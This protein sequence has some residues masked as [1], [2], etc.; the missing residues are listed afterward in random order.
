[1]YIINKSSPLHCRK[2]FSNSLLRRKPKSTEYGGERR[3]QTVCGL[4]EPSLTKLS[5]VTGP[6]LQIRSWHNRVEHCDHCPAQLTHCDDN[7]GEGQ[8][9]HSIVARDLLQHSNHC[10]KR[11]F[12]TSLR[13]PSLEDPK[14]SL[15]SPVTVNMEASKQ[16]LTQTDHPSAC[17]QT[18]SI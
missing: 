15:L 7:G 3:W 10:F 5:A 18:N 6:G 2:F 17:S 13:Q 14:F 11:S 1:M 12:F 8:P 9:A 16:T 4:N